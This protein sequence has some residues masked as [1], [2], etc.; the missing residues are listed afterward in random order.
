MQESKDLTPSSVNTVEVDESKQRT[1]DALD[2]RRYV[3]VLSMSNEYSNWQDEM[4]SG[5][6]FRSVLDQHTIYLSKSIST[7]KSV[8]D[9]LIN[10]S[11]FISLFRF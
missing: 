5:T 8:D 3:S 11:V 7:L 2:M 4:Q 9:V 6:S 10:S 1:T